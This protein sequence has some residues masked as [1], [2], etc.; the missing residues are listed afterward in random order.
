MDDHAMPTTTTPIATTRL[1]P[2]GRARRASILAELT[3]GMATLHRARA[4]RRAVARG[5]T[6]A[7]LLVAV[8]VAATTAVGVRR[9]AAPPVI[10]AVPP[11]ASG[12][13]VIVFAEVR[14]DASVVDRWSARPARVVERIDDK[15][16]LDT[17]YAMDRPSGLVR[18]GD[19]VW[20]TRD[21]TEGG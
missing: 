14:T 9:G 10:A 21:V 13:T 19:D 2:A 1:S 15:A 3:D 6:V 18:R 5:A 20:L 17:L 16:L 11:A 7:G 4:R 12:P 8:A